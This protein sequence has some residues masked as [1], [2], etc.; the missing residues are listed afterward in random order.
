MVTYHSNWDIYDFMAAVIMEETIPQFVCTFITKYPYKMSV[1]SYIV[2]GFYE[3]EFV[4]H[5]S[6]P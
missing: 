6:R 4:Q 5:S 2:N 3:I 1:H